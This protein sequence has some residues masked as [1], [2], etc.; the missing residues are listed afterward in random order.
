MNRKKFISASLLASTAAFLGSKIAF[1]G[2][3]KTAEAVQK[4]ADIKIIPGK[5]E[6]LTILNLEILVNQF[7]R[8]WFFMPTKK[9]RQQWEV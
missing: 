2:N 5:H 3:S 9:V 6:E 4:V 1:G 8:K 7:K